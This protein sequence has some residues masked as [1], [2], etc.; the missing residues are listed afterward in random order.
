MRRRHGEAAP[1]IE[2][3]RV[4][5]VLVTEGTKAPNPLKHALIIDPDGR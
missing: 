5:L 4:T 1:E 3:P 2:Q